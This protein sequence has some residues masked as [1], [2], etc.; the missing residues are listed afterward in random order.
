M[1]PRLMVF[2]GLAFT[3]LTRSGL[4]L[5]RA[6]GIYSTTS[7]VK[8]T[9]ATHLRNQRQTSTP[10]VQDRL[11]LALVLAGRHHQPLVPRLLPLLP[12]P[13]RRLRWLNLPLP[14]LLRLELL[15][16]KTRYSMWNSR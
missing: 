4:D 16:S 7:T 3:N 11:A 2:L 6:G 15:A 14:F 10:T 13:Q 5:V 1:A 8:S 12:L 9:K